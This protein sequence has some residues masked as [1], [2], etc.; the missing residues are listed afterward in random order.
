MRF[1]LVSESSVPEETG[2]LLREACEARG[3]PFET[4]IAKAFDFDPLRRL[5][6]GD[7]L[8]KAA[9]SIAAS[10]AEQFLYA[11]G[12]A[13]FHSADGGIFLT[14]DNQTLLAESAGIPTPKTVYLASSGAALLKKHAESLGGF[15]VVVKVLGRSGGIGVMLAE[16]MAALR[17]LA[18]FSIAQGQNPLLCQFIPNAIHWRLIVLGDRVIASYRNKQVAD[19]FRSVGSTNRD[20]FEA[21]PP[22]AAIETAVRSARALRLEFAGVDI[23]ENPTGQVF[24]LEANFPCYYPH[25][26]LHG[27]VD[28]AGQMV[29]FLAGKAGHERR[30]DIRRLANTPDVCSIDNFVD[31]RDCERVLAKAARIETE[32]PAYIPLKRDST[33]LSFEMPIADDALLIRIAGDI[34]RVVGMKNDLSLTFRFRHYA[35]GESHCAHLDEYEIS[36]RRL[37]ATAILYLTDTDS[38]GETHFPHAKPA[39]LRIEPLRGRLSVWFNC[40]ANGSSEPA[41]LHESLPVVEGAKSTI[42]MFIYKKIEDYA[43]A[44]AESPALQVPLILDAVPQPSTR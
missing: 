16:S 1:C 3:I 26:Q 7:L 37:V 32:R 15:P 25:A 36:G 40:R 38:G 35:E 33:G 30:Y 43:A 42:T 31:A 19:D 18:D 22:A 8:Y 41:S 5:R 21:K 2:R 20:D 39:P 44:R 6:A 28:I 13:T 29:D 10:R 4:V 24:F 11:P 34:D 12:V 9:G 17:S 14:I 23:L 27:G